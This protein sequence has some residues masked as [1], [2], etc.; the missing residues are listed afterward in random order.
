MRAGCGGGA[1]A[2]V[3]GVL[4][5]PGAQGGWRQGQQKIWCARRVWQPVLANTLQYFCLENPSLTEKP[6]G[7]QC[8]GLQRVEHDQSDP[9][10]TDARL[11]PCVSSAPERVEC[12]GG[13]AA[14]LSGP[15]VAPS[16]QGHGRPPLQGSRPDQS[17]EPLVADQKASLASLSP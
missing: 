4:A 6:G 16:V 12:E 10:C 8:K 7:P 13:A 9:A 17:F 5:A 14:W 15:L 11:S 1:A 2:C 3:A